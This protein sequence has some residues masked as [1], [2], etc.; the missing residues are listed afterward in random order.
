MLSYTIKLYSSPVSSNSNLSQSHYASS[1]LEHSLTIILTITHFCSSLTIMSETSILPHFYHI[2][3]MPLFT[4]IFTVF[5]KLFFG[6]DKTNRV[7]YQCCTIYVQCTLML[8][9]TKYCTLSRYS[10][11]GTV[12]ILITFSIIYAHT[13]HL[14]AITMTVLILL[15]ARHQSG[16]DAYTG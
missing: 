13:L 1:Q 16:G 7:F 15:S 4:V 12:S 5:A 14:I 10:L 11:G 9:C 3:K 6:I 2:I 8:P